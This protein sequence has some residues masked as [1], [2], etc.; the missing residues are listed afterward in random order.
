LH[1]GQRQLRLRPSPL[2]ARLEL[3]FLADQLPPGRPVVALTV[4]AF[5]LA[6]QEWRT[7]LGPLEPAIPVEDD[8]LAPVV[9]L[10]AVT[11]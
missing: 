10:G 11:A 7:A 2:G 5:A 8:V 4:A 1:E 6:D 9:E 3:D